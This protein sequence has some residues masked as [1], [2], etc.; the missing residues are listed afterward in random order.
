MCSL[1]EGAFLVRMKGR[2]WITPSYHTM[3]INTYRYAVI[4]ALIPTVT[5][6]LHNNVQLQDV[7]STCLL[8]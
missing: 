6:N 1:T 4:D 5:Q 8:R 2:R 3:H 7:Q